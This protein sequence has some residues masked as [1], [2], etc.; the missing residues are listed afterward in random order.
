MLHT[1]PARVMH[2]EM[3][4]G[5]TNQPRFLAY[6][7]IFNIVKV[8]GDIISSLSSFKVNTAT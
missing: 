7:V 3:T 5:I 1:V 8:K 4:G 6:R 2:K